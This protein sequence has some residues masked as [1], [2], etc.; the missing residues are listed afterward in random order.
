MKRPCD[1]IT[2]QFLDIMGDN[3]QDLIGWLEKNKRRAMK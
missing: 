2:R 1:K 3:D